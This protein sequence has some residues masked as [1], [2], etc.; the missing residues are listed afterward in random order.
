LILG[1]LVGCG[2]YGGLKPRAPSY[3]NGGAVRLHVLLEPGLDE[4]HDDYDDHAWAADEVR[5]ELLARLRGHNWAARYVQSDSGFA[6]RSAGPVCVRVWVDLVKE[7]SELG[8]TIGTLVGSLP[9]HA[10]KQAAKSKCRLGFQI[11]YGDG[12]QPAYEGTHLYRSHHG[13]DSVV[14]GVT[15]TVAKRITEEMLTLTRQAGTG[16]TVTGP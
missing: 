2:G 8:S 10:I 6:D 14:E 1:A 5:E 9:G 7:G 4:G 3:A 15:K 12:E 13:W 11:F 16:A